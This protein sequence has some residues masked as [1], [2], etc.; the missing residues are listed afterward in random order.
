MK[1]VYAHARSTRKVFLVALCV[2]S[3]SLALAQSPAPVRQQLKGHVTE[4]MMKTPLE[5]RVPP[6]TQMTLT[7]GLVIPNMTALTQTGRRSRIRTAPRI[8][9]I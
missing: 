7:I 2:F 9:S 8:E 6:T 5:G 4:A 1:R 3:G